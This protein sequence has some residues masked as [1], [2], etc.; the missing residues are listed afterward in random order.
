MHGVRLVT[1][2]DHRGLVA[3]IERHFPGAAWQRC[4]V[5]FLRNAGGKVVRKH[6]KALT[7]DLKAVY[8]APAKGWALE[9]AGDFVERWSETHRPSPTESRTASKRP[10]RNSRFPRRTDPRPDTRTA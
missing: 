6:R 9:H 10:W 3:T 2:D 4:Y 8:A 1:S 7:S 5:H